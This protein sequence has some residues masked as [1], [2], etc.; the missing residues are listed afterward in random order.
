MANTASLISY[1]N[2]FGEW[3]A[4]TNTLV[5]E[6][7]TLAANNYTKGS[8]TLFLNDPLL[9]L[10][11]ANNAILGGQLQ[12]VGIG[13]SAYVQNNLRV[14]SQVYFTNTVL[15][16]TNA[17]Q[18]NIGG[19]ILALGANV[20]I[21]VTNNAI[22]GANTTIG[23]RLSVAGNTTISSNATVTN[24]L[25]AG[26]I[27]SGSITS[28]SNVNALYVNSTSDITGMDAYLRN[29]YST[30]SVIV[31]NQLSVLGNFLIS[32]SLVYDT[33]EL[34][35]N[36]GSSIGVTSKFAVNRGSSGANAEIRWNESNDYF[37]IRDVNNPVSYSKIVTAN[38]I[39]D[40]VGLD[41][42]NTI[43]SSKAVKYVND[44]ITSN[45]VTL[46][47][48]IATLNTSIV[49]VSIF[50]QSAY[51][52]ANSSFSTI[53]GTSGSATQN[54]SSISIN[55][56]N[57][58][59]VSGTGNTLTISTPQDIR[60]SA[61]PTFDGLVL[62]NALPINQ[63]GTGATSSSQA[64]TNLLP[65]GTSAGY[66][67]T[68]GGPGT[69]YWA[70]GGGGSG[71]ATI[72]GTTISSTRLYPSVNVGQTIFSAPTYV[73]GASQLRV[74]INGVRQFN[75]EYSETT[76]TS[77]TLNNGCS[78]G[79]IVL[80]EVD[81]Y[82][83][84]P[85]Y[86]NTIA[87]TAPFGGIVSSA[88]NIQLAIQDIETRKATL[89]SPTFTGTPTAP[90]PTTTTSNT[91]I[92]TT[93]FANTLLIGGTSN[94]Y[95]RTIGVGTTADTANVG[96]ILATGYIVANYSDESLKNRLGNIENA[97]DKLMTLDGFYYEPNE[98]AQKLGYVAK[99]EVG[100][101]AQQV[102]K[103]MPEVI[104]PAPIDNKYLT[105]NYERLVPL[106]IESIKELKNEVELLKSKI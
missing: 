93:A 14:D 89:I 79:D 32:G 50:A 55:S 6:N 1:T 53:R 48:N 97:L 8:G 28:T 20:G 15:G 90:T 57:G 56:T 39:S 24:S 74:Y 58:I 61:T 84:Y 36:S 66:V 30:G 37:E 19:P 95:L 100:V 92:A 77:F 85:Y 13:S 83:N 64:L 76:N 21:N 7:N 42:S 11:V 40:A 54:G 5:Q 105:V 44:N 70:A 46:S 86:A 62:S 82:I 2:T 52:K 102:E 104:S 68:T 59:I 35:I 78:S 103:V 87:F 41:D 72:P 96:S 23:G 12:V 38:L 91:Q 3:L 51:D 73:P 27:Y 43:A 4:S 88:N 29:V 18:A 17:G 33:N 80:V 49:N 106:L 98:T 25:T 16:I 101:S 99:R 63:G 94:A 22:I 67:L 69:F 10:Q 65:T 60:T 71:G 81:G 34:V 45:A 75:S 9:G 31:G 26:S 47:S